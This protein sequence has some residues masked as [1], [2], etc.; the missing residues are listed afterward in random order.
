MLLCKSLVKEISRKGIL[1]A[2]RNRRV[3]ATTGDQIIVDF[4]LN[5]SM[6]GQAIEGIKKP[7]LD[8]SIQAVDQIEKIDILRNSK[9]I[10]SI[11]PEKELL[12][13]QGIYIDEDYFVSV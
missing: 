2:I 9:V 10:K 6:Q 11:Q 1:E 4:R 5:G 3:F 12:D 13:L 7:K 8:F